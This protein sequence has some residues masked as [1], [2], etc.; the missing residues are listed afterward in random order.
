MLSNLEAGIRNELY[1]SF[2][3]SLKIVPVLFENFDGEFAYGHTENFI[4]IKAKSDSKLSGEIKYV[5]LINY[6]SE[7]IYGEIVNK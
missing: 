1:G 4:E 6:D 2:V 3:K 7:R 5:S